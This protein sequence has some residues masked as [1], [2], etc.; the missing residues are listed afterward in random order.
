[1]SR[2]PFTDSHVHFHDLRA[3]GLRYTWL[4]H[5]AEPDPALGDYGAI[6]SECY[7][8]EDYI[9]ETRRHNVRKVIH[10]QCALGT[11]DPVRETEWLHEAAERTG[12]PH[13]VVAAADL[14][15]PD[16]DVTLSRH[17]EHPLVRGIRDLRADDY[18][19]DPRWR[20]GFAR[21]GERG[22]VCCVSP[23][24]ERYGELAELAKRH[25]ATT[26]CLDH[27]GFPR[28]SD[29]DYFWAWRDG[30]RRLAEAPNVVVKISGLGHL[31]PAWTAETLRPWVTTCIELFGA[32]RA[33]FGSSWPVE[34]LFG[35]FGDQLDAFAELISSAS[36][37]EQE[38]LFYATAERVFAI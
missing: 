12:I 29:D 3:P 18:L 36:R 19:V 35:S 32:E 24:V 37:A 14:T 5:G 6:R 33:F 31:N 11:E 16:L 20:E 30:L 1:M 23:P 26:V 21:L 38:A 22:L 2:L 27:A 34:R 25:P 4:E 17:L 10:V 7:R 28:R 8:A 13:A 9:G 15:A